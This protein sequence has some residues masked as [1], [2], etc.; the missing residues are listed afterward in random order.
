MD[1]KAL[2]E[3]IDMIDKKL[4]EP[5]VSVQDAYDA[6]KAIALWCDTMHNALWYDLIKQE[7]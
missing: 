7:A 3:I 1:S 4:N 6:Y 2:Q 5:G